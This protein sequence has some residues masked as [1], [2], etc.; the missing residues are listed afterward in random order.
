MKVYQILNDLEKDGKLKKLID[1]G[2]ISTTMLT[3]RDAFL[4]FDKE[5]ILGSKKG[6]AYSTA[7]IE[8]GV[9]ENTVKK[10]VKI[11]NT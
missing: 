1:A 9:H 2:V 5:I 4:L 6:G 7:A 10:A 11:M 3:Y 8:L